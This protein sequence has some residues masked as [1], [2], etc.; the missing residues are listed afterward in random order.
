M[1]RERTKVTKKINKFRAYE[2]TWNNYT[3]EDVKYVEELECKYLVYGKE[4]GEQGTPHL[5]GLIIFKYQKTFN[6]ARKMFKNNHI[7]AAKKNYNLMMY[8]KKGEQTKEEWK[9]YNIK[10]P[11][12]GKNADVFEKGEAPKDKQ[13]KQQGKRNDLQD[14]Y[15]MIKKEAPM[16]EIR[17]KY[18]GQCIRYGQAIRD[19]SI[20]MTLETNLKREKELYSKMKLFKWQKDVIEKINNQNSRQI[21]WVHETT[22]NVGKSEL[23]KYLEV[24]KNTFLISQG[25]RDDIAYAYKFQPIVAIDVTRTGKEFTNYSLI[26]AF[27]NGRLFSPK[28]H[29]RQLT[30]KYAKVVVFSNHPPKYIDEK[31]ELTLSEDRWDIYTPKLTNEEKELIKKKQNKKEVKEVVEEQPETNSNF[32]FSK[33]DKQDQNKAKLWELQM[34]EDSD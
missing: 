20:D 16:S 27:K 24:V 11:N 4:V 2:F 30:F 10:G 3:S 28:Y 18:P 5:Q 34:D 26:E 6:A 17:E 1:V 14:I 9:Q 19:M 21:L 15:E 13:D 31:G 29:S 8:C 33:R 7:E 12:Y 22:G 23:A 32:N 25:K